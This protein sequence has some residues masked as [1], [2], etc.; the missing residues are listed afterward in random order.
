LKQQQLGQH[1]RPLSQ[2]AAHPLPLSTSPPAGADSMMDRWVY[3]P[4]KV[5]DKYADVVDVASWSSRSCNCFTKVSLIAALTVCHLW[6]PLVCCHWQE[7]SLMAQVLCSQARGVE[8][9]TG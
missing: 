8:G 5:L 2:Q 6:H 1:T 3:L 7:G 4:D 9:V